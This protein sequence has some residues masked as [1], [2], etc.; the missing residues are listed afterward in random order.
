MTICITY[1]ENRL[2]DFIG[3]ETLLTIYLRSRVKQHQC[4]NNL[5]SIAFQAQQS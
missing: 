5:Y 2:F 1:K 4:F 3:C